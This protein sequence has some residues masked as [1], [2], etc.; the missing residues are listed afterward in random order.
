MHGM[1]ANS[2]GRDPGA[3]WGVV[4]PVKPLP[5]AK[6]RLRGAVPAAEHGRRWRSTR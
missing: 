2:M 6:A 5:A 1:D 3:G 4:V